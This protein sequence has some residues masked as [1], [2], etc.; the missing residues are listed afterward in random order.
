MSRIRGFSHLAVN[1]ADL[2]RFRRFYCDVLGLEHLVTMKMEHPPHLRH[3]AIGVDDRCVLHVFEVPGYDPEAD[4]IGTD[5]GQRG[6]IDH[7]GLMVDDM[8]D[9]EAVRDRLVASGAS[10]GE[11]R[12]LG[13]VWSIRFCDP[14]G[15]AGE[16]NCALLGF[17][18]GADDR[19][20]VEEM[21]STDWIDRLAGAAGVS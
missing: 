8:A 20:T 14:D 19:E 3:A 16:V 18:P 6:R 7:F 5:I 11:I 17:D 12:P 13:P 21:E 9:L 15:L 10:D 2:D 4:G 1:T